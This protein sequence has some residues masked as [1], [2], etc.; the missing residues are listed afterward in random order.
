MTLVSSSFVIIAENKLNERAQIANFLGKTFDQP[1]NILFYFIRFACVG[2]CAGISDTFNYAS[3]ENISRNFHSH[4]Q[5][6]FIPAL[7]LRFNYSVR[8]QKCTTRCIENK[9]QH[10]TTTNLYCVECF[11]VD[12]FYNMKW[13]FTL[14]F[15]PPR[16]VQSATEK[17]K[18]VAVR[19][20]IMCGVSTLIC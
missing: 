8:S 15:L 16:N 9:I 12:Y 10:A 11:C 13:C 2:F 3:T 6:H 14:T 17:Q 1:K 5:E 19:R 7:G 20:E 4:P 18:L